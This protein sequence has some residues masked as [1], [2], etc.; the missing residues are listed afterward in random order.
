MTPYDSIRRFLRTVWSTLPRRSWLLLALMVAGVL[1]EGLGILLLVPLLHLVGLDLGGGALGRIGAAVD[2]AFAALGLAPTLPLVLLV[3]VVLVAGRALI[4][5]RQ[6]IESARIEQE[7]VL[8]LRTR[9][10]AAITHSRWAFFVRRK[11]ADFLHALVEDLYR[12]S[13]AVTQLLRLLTQLLVGLAYLVIAFGVSPWVTAVAALCGGGLLLALRRWNERARATGARVSE[14]TRAMFGALHEHVAAMK[15]TKSYGAEERNIRRFRTLAAAASQAHFRVVREQAAFTAIFALGAVAILS[16]IVYVS[17]ELLSV[18]PAGLLLLLFLFARLVPRFSS[19]QTS[20]HAFINLVPAFDR[21]MDLIEAAEAAR[22]PTADG[23]PVRLGDRV[24]LQ[25]VRFSYV[26][27]SAPVLDGFDLVIP[28]RRTTA[29]VGPSGAGK[30]TVADLVMGLLQPDAGVVR[31]DDVA[32]GPGNR[33][34][35]R[36]QIGY[37]PQEPFLFH[38]TIRANLLWARPDASE[39]QCWEAL[40]MAAAEDFVARFPAGLDTVVGDRGALVSGG[41]RQRL[42]LA[43]ALLRSPALL[44]LDEATSALDPKNELEVR[45]AV[46]GLHGK[47]TILIISHRLSSIRDADRIHVID[48]GRITESGTW[49]ELAARPRGVFREMCRLQGLVELDG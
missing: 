16:L 6:S 5:Y 14:D 48:R 33:R 23:L 29:V 1:T 13:G 22:E 12:V 45:A 32:L 8:R 40:R 43:R 17:I 34:A 35:W 27:A 31:V 42:V 36:R 7:F 47:T 11:G 44:V 9:L 2:G 10:Y 39:E 18:P 41:E 30:S 38:D 46:R 21:C 49:E 3:F 37:V 28:A 20:Y 26:D 19:A 24:E 15:T 25:D 4:Q